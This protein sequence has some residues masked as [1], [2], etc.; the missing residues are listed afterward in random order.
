MRND[1]FKWCYVL[2]IL[3]VG[4]A[5][6]AA[7]G[8]LTIS[9]LYNDAELIRRIWKGN[10]IVTLALVVPLFI[11][12]MLLSKRGSIHARLVWMGLLG[13][14]L[15]NYAFYLFGAAFNKFFLLYVAIFALSVY[16]LII[17][18]SSI[19]M[20]ALKTGLTKTKAY[21]WISVYLLFIALPLGLFEVNQCI[22][23][24]ITGNSP[25]APPLIFALDLS[26]IVPNSALAAILLW[27]GSVWGYVLG[28]IMLV[29]AFTYGLVLSITTAL[30]AG[31]RLSGNWD[32][33]MPFYVFVT[34]GGFLCV[35][36]LLSKLKTYNTLK[37]S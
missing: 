37:P 22:N 15:Y 17:G 5:T 29:K 36:I 10:D 18:L 1:N 27:K 6:I 11:I 7:V 14:T 8:G 30:V 16:A 23:Y 28:T 32:P 35:S 4:L 33:L 34:V 3:T 12:T 26:I 13:Y 24:V 31:F 19:N 25:T 2:S 9:K 21:K 20:R